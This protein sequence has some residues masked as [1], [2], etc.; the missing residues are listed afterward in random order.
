MGYALPIPIY[1]EL[2][3]EQCY[4]CACWFAFPKSLQARCRADVTTFFCPNG[5]GQVYSKSDLMKVREELAAEKVRHQ[6]TLARENE[7][8]AENNRLERR[9]KRVGRG[10]CPECNRTFANLARHMNCK[11]GAK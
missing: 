5:H 2:V 11:H 4:K 6:A 7:A 8:R 1:D 9:L 10:V 3:T